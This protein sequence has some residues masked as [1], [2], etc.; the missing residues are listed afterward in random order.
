MFVKNVR[1]G[2][3]IVL[4]KNKRPHNLETVR[5]FITDELWEDF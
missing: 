3:K 4:F 2:K 1:E 5:D